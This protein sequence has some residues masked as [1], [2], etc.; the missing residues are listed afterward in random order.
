M[1][2]Q[3]QF[4]NWRRKGSSRRK[5]KWRSGRRKR[6]SR[7]GRTRTRGRR[8]RSSWM[9]RRV[10]GSCILALALVP[11][12]IASLANIDRSG[13]TRSVAHV[14][15]NEWITILIFIS[16][17]YPGLLREYIIGPLRMYYI[18]TAMN[19]AYLYI[20]KYSDNSSIKSF[21]I[22][23]EFAIWLSLFLFVWHN[24][25]PFCLSDFLSVWLLFSLLTF[26]L[27]VFPSDFLSVWPSDCSE[28]LC[29][30]SD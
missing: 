23:E 26:C 28:W 12:V 30:L 11:S 20:S 6:S 14:N 21:I 29:R 2:K 7:K 4:A 22:S 1:Q 15:N 16:I 25:C 8:K 10:G 24:V 13:N 3:W 5:R 19:D 17:Y 27:S 9:K 18:C